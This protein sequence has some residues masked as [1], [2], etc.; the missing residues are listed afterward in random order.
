MITKTG[1]NAYEKIIV[2]RS[3]AH[4]VGAQ[5]S[6]D[7]NQDQKEKKEKAKSEQSAKPAEHTVTKPG[8]QPSHHEGTQTKQHE[9]VEASQQAAHAKMHES[10][11]VNDTTAAKQKGTA[12]RTTTVFRNGKQTSEHLTLR[13][14]TRER[15][16][17]HFS[18]GTHPR[19]WWLTTYPIVLLEGCYYYLADNGCWY[20]AYGFD[21]GC[22]FPIGVVFCE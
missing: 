17:V 9:Q 2:S 13:R 1:R 18:I 6:P 3:W 10:A 14:G 4:S 20:P 22:T 12:I 21:P 11:K 5:T 8:M 16:D 15:T 19:E 7:E